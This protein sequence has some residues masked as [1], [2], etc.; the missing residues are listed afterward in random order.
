MRCGMLPADSGEPT[1]D[2]FL[3]ALNQPT[4]IRP[5]Y[6]CGVQRVRADMTDPHREA[7]D[8]ELN[9]LIAARREGIAYR[10]SGESLGRLLSAHGYQIRGAV[11]Q[12]HVAGRCACGR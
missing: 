6:Q 11:I 4:S 1:M 10:H 7:F 12:N 5:G 9:N 3:E 2:D 8:R